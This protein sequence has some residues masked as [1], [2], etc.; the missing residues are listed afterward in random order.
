MSGDVVNLTYVFPLADDPELRSAREYYR[1]MAAFDESEKARRFNSLP[2][3]ERLQLA[4]RLARILRDPHPSQADNR[5]LFETLGRH[6]TLD[7]RTGIV[8]LR[9]R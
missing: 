4:A 3:A 8:T 5:F 9:S 6:N 2:D 1:A 7:E